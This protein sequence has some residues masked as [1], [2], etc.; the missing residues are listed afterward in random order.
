MPVEGRISEEITTKATM[1]VNDYFREKLRQKA[2]ARALAA[3]NSLP[4]EVEN[5]YAVVP[6]AKPVGGVTFE[7]RKTVLD[8]TEPVAESSVPSLE[9][10]VAQEESSKAEGK[11]RKREG[12]AEVPTEDVSAPAGESK[13]SKREGTDKVKKESKDEK[14]ARKAAKQA[15]KEAKR[16][17]KEAK[18]AQKAEKR[19]R[20][21]AAE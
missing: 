19:A 13:K 1:S 18:A 8:E 12:P 11:K 6:D 16:A 9:V 14:A 7:G 20:K 4:V 10:R 3:G 5:K 15:E 21:A 2:V 17:A